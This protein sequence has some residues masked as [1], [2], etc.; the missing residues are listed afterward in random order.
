MAAKKTGSRRD[1]L[2][3][4]GFFARPDDDDPSAF[5]DLPLY[6][7]EEIRRRLAITSTG[8]ELTAYEM[9]E[10][11]HHGRQFKVGGWYPPMEPWFKYGIPNLPLAVL[12]ERDV[13]A[14]QEQ[15]ERISQVTV[16]EAITHCTARGEG[17]ALRGE[18]PADGLMGYIWRVARFY[19][20]TELRIPATA[21]MDAGVELTLPELEHIDKVARDMLRRMGLDYTA[22]DRRWRRLIGG[23]V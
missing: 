18:K 11:Y 2:A 3:W 12:Q 15:L 13:T 22:P 14:T 17:I 9:A 6:R 16:E 7:Q 19:M 4:A 21:D 1:Y 10:I 20:G 5:D 8:R 23:E